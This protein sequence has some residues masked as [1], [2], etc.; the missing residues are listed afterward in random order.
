[1]VPEKADKDTFWEH[2]Y[3]YRFATQFVAGRTV[4][5]IACGEGYGAAALSEAGATKVVGV[6]ISP[7]TCLHATQKYGIETRI[8]AGEKIPLDSSS[9]DVVVSFETIEHVRNP[10]VF[11]DECHRVL[12]PNGSL[13]IST[14]NHDSARFYHSNN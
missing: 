11:L 3:R 8:G 12:R 9:I 1:M 7:E 5:D 2:I 13:V 6:D 4:L 14:P 10:K